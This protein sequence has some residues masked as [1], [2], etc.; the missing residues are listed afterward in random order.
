MVAPSVS[1]PAAAAPGYDEE[2]RGVPRGRLLSLDALRGLT[3]AAMI[4]VNNPGSQH[5]VYPPLRHAAW[6]GW[7][8]ADLIFPFFLFIM[9]IST[10]LSLDTRQH[11]GQGRRALLRHIALR[12]S[13]LILLGLL[14]NGLF[15]LPFD[16]VRFP[17]VLQRIGIVYFCS[18]LI[19][20]ATGRRARTILTVALLLSYWALLMLV[21]VP[22]HGAGD[23]SPAGN[24]ASYVDVRL[25]TGH[26]W[27]QTFD[28]EGILSTLPAIATALLGTLTA[29]WLRSARQPKQILLKLLAAGAAGLM[30]GEIWNIWFPI[31][32][33]LWTSSY[34]VFTAGF[35]LLALAACYWFMD[36]QRWRGWALP[37]VALG[38]NPL[39]I[40]A[41]SEALGGSLI[42][43]R[44]PGMHHSMHQWVYRHLLAGV[45]AAPMASLLWAL[46][47]LAAW[48]AVA[49]IMYRNTIFIRL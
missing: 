13:I 35:G 34:V 33:T 4:L 48:W 7:T 27:T 28:P 12:S 26:M 32:K 36:V 43:F 19:V 15:F 10:A 24:L 29:G 21:P 23:L 5:T 44:W 31:N 8:P 9:G 47:Y 3:I 37:L 22:G 49:W 20:M 2:P 41:G 40:Y 45:A 11:N 17:G 16:H 25:M 39:V 14:L 46:A 1:R 6:H 42:E 30:L 18:A 38:M